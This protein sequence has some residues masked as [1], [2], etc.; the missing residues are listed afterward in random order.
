MA[1]EF[2]NLIAVVMFNFGHAIFKLKLNLSYCK[3]ILSTE[4]TL[5]NPNVEHLQRCS[6]KLINKEY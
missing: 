4:N 1:N 3:Y 2:F 6:T 5:T